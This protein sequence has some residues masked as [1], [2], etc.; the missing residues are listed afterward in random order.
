V[1]SSRFISVGLL[2]CLAVTT[3]DA[4][5]DLLWQHADGRLAVWTMDG[6]VSVSGD[7]LGLGQLPDPRWQLVASGDF[8]SDPYI[9]HIFQHQGDGRLAVWLMNRHALV[10]GFG[11][12]P[13]QEPDLNWKVRGAADFDG[14]FR[15][16]LIWQN[17]VTGQV[18]VWLMAGTTLREIRVL[19]SV[20]DTEWRIVG[21]ADF[22]R[23]EQ[24][25]ILWQHQSN[26]LIALWYM[27]RLSVVDG[28]LVSNEVS[29]R[30]LKIRAVGPLWGEW[31]AL[32]WQNQET[33]LLA[34]W[35]MYDR[36]PI[37]SV[38]LSPDRVADM[39][40]RIVGVHYSYDPGALDY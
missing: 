4:Q 21:P 20:Q 33:G 17:Q 30:N 8:N 26:G 23:D 22:N 35:V 40:W 5:T 10:T 15:P 11:L 36:S 27:N 6:W 39:G 29:D 34:T 18:R 37:F 25:D 1:T 2:F 12:T 9:D 28:V 19:P 3:A 7:P 32:I 31:P 38:L 13:A 16:D 14:D 24:V